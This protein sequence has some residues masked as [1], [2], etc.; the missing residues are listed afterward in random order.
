VI[1]ILLLLSSFVPGILIFALPEER[2][3]LRGTLNLAGAIAKV[4]LVAVLLREVARGNEPAV[5]F[6][7]VPGIPLVLRVDELALLFIAL[8]AV[9]WLLTTSYLDGAPHR[10]R[11]FGFFSL[12]VT[13]T[14]GIALAGNLMTFLV[15]Y[16]ALTLTTYPL[17]VHR[18]TEAALQAG[19]VYLT[20]ALGGGIV[21]LA[22]IAWLHSLAGSVLFTRGG[23]LGD[24][25]AGNDAALTGIFI[26][27]IAGLAVKAAIVP[28]HGW[29]ARAMVAPAPVSAL[30]HAVAVV[31][32]GAF[33]ILRV[34]EDVYGLTLLSTLGLLT[35]LAIAGAVT[36]LYG[37]LRALSQDDLKRRLAYS[38]VSQVSY[39]VLGAA[40]LA[41]LATVGALAHL[42]HQ[43][44]MKITL[45][46]TAGVLAETL[47]IH[48]VSQ[49]A[50]VGRRM[51][52]TMTAFTIGALGMVGIP[53]TAGFVSKWYIGVGALDAGQGW[54]LAILVVSGVLNAAYFLPIVYV[55]WFRDPV[56]DAWDPA[57]GRLEA[58]GSLL[59][60]ALIT[61]ALS[62]AAGIFAGFALSPVSLAED[63]APGVIAP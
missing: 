19:R 5:E 62:L 48:R 28:L 37:S 2:H 32:A 45:F 51:P 15:F 14:V 46:F 30:L 16:E 63:L 55:A 26:L 33:G 60:P 38:T 39:I 22:G 56:P 13:A 35:P 40:L 29:L 61:A 47:G 11:F 1:L 36:I 50:G 43:G 4:A 57:D 21:L 17:I 31:K 42:V 58:K 41:P 53:P 59:A 3:R 9:L 27:L 18:G 10:S 6:G 20:Y 23:A 52:W 8:S 49:M 24:V 7:F 44:V 12:C 54:A 34:V 25:A